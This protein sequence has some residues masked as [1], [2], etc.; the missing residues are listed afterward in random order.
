MNLCGA[1]EAVCQSFN[2]V[3]RQ[4]HNGDV[5]EKGKGT[6]VAFIM[7]LLKTPFLCNNKLHFSTGLWL[8]LDLCHMWRY[9]I[10]APGQCHP[11]QFL[12]VHAPLS[13]SAGTPCQDRQQQGS[14]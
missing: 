9:Y 11:F 6:P 2:T 3:A 14:G 4:N 10:S 13:N 1:L 7:D 8:A 12:L 5:G